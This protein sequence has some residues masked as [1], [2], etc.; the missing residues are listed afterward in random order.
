MNS[1]F[2]KNKVVLLTGHTG[3][4]G[5]W[6]SLW[7]QQ[8]GAKVIGYALAPPTTPNLF[9]KADVASGM[10]S[11]TGDIRNLEKVKQVFTEFQPEIVIHLAAQPL[12]RYS[13]QHPIETYETNMMGS[14]NILKRLEQQIPYVLLLW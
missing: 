14:L 6:L 2:W 7:L 12:V 4:K 10:Q 1:E 5:S 13:Y 3:F 11:I 8:L 9:E